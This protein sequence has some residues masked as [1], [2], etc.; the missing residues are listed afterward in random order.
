[1][2]TMKNMLKKFDDSNDNVVDILPNICVSEDED[3]FLSLN[4]RYTVG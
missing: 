2:M 1:M 4:Y 3:F